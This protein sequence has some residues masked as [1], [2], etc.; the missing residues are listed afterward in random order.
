MQGEERRKEP[1]PKKDRKQST[2]RERILARPEDQVILSHKYSLVSICLRTNK[3]NDL[4]AMVQ[5]IK[6]KLCILS[7]WTFPERISICTIS[8]A[9][10][11][12]VFIFEAKN[13]E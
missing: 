3:L 2:R 8:I 10:K 5:S 11:R 13:V 7:S 6:Y 9:R 1:E 4:K 12:G